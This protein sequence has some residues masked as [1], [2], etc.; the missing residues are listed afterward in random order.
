MPAAA[1]IIAYDLQLRKNSG[2]WTEVGLATALATRVSINL[3]L[4]TSLQF[5]V[6]AG[7]SAGQTGPWTTGPIEKPLAYQETSSTITYAGSW[8]TKTGASDW[9]GHLKAASHA[10]ASATFHLTGRAVAIVASRGPTEGSGQIYVDGTLVTTVNLHTSAPTVRQIV[11]S[12][13]WSSFSS[14]TV[15]LV[16]LGTSGHPAIDLD[17][18][19]ILH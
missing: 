4:S 5:R 15:K 13:A 12:R 19:A 18:F 1:P 9:G 11:F 10:S 2:A 8:S 16:V 7:D 14:H 17:G 6:R 3:P